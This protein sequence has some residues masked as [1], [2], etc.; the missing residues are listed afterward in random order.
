MLETGN[1]Q[2]CKWVA[3]RDWAFRCRFKKPEGGGPFYLDFLG[4][5]AVVDIYLNGRLE[6][7]HRTMFMP[8]PVPA[9]ALLPEDELMLYFHSPHKALQ[10]LEAEIPPEQAGKIFPYCVLRKPRQDFLDHGGTN[11][12]YTPVGTFDDVCLVC[13]DQ[14]E[15]EDLDVDIRINEDLSRADISVRV[16]CLFGEGLTPA[17]TLEAPDGSPVYTAEGGPEG[18][19]REENG[20]LILLSD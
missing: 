1:A 2:A 15:F 19:E 4:L 16:T 7:R 5:D 14:S 12:Y 20:L 6:T 10:S 9:P 17:L 3:E 11:P 18:W 13:V 8:A